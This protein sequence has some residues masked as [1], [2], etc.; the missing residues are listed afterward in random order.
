MP[1]RLRARPGSGSRHGRRPSLR[2]AVLLV[3]AL[4]LC[5]YVAIT[6]RA[7]G[8]SMPALV[9]LSWHGVRLPMAAAPA[10]MVPAYGA[11]KVSVASPVAASGRAAAAPPAA[12]AQP[13]PAAA[14]P[15]PPPSS[16]GL[17]S[18]S[19]AATGK[20]Q[21]LY[22]FAIITRPLAFRR[23][24]I[25]R[26]TWLHCLRASALAAVP[27]AVT[28]RY[29]FFIGQMV[30]DELKRAQA[31]GR[32]A[33][34]ADELARERDIVPL[35]SD[36]QYA[37][38]TLKSQLMLHW[39]AS[40]WVAA[41]GGSLPRWRMHP[42]RSAAWDANVSAAMS[43]LTAWAEEASAPADEHLG[44]RPFEG[45]GERLL[46]LL[47]SAARRQSPGGV[48]VDEAESAS[49]GLR[50]WGQ[51]F[52]GLPVTA[53][54]IAFE[55]L[56]KTDEDVHYCP[57]HILRYG[58]ALM[59]VRGRWTRAWKNKDMPPVLTRD[60]AAQLHEGSPAYIWAGRGPYG[61]KP[62]IRCVLGCALCV[63]GAMHAHALATTFP[64]LRA[65]PIST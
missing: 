5:A 24:A 53:G 8:Y 35:A 11:S 42:V 16:V 54:G 57:G 63:S 41:G 47:Q 10:V 62:I 7:M 18:L 55:Y 13:L 58:A 49:G 9:A 65:F 33:L 27:E 1:A 17:P 6:M 46:D 64:P 14:A 23:R 25:I 38:L 4:L 48:A 21:R 12:A 20:R 31:S 51:P 30:G 22:F 29:R 19:P 15:R 3:T 52:L 45:G 28:L 32:D 43:G 60:E 50:P 39:V 34:L 61:R 37:N 26:A 2:C 40:E 59:V 36:D 56:V 44:G